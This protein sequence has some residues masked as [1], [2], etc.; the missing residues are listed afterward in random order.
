MKRL[1]ET[2][3]FKKVSGDPETIKEMTLFFEMLQSKGIDPTSGK[4]PST[5]QLLKLLGDSE[6]KEAAKRLQARFQALGVDLQYPE[7]LAE[8]S[9]LKKP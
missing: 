3:L 9:A 5:M 1:S 2:T 6:F 7:V 8:L 4:N